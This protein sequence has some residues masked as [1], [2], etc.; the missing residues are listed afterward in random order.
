LLY[1][2]LVSKITLQKLHTKC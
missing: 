1:E 2:S